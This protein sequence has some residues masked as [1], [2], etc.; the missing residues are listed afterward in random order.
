MTKTSG[1]LAHEI[2]KILEGSPLD[3]AAGAIA[4]VLI[5][6]MAQ[7]PSQDKKMVMQMV[8]QETA[9]ITEAMKKKGQI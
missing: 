7:V 8:A 9:R 4:R 6:L 3:V 2:G 1:D 5:A